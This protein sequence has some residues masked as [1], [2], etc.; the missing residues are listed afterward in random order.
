MWPST[1]AGGA[2]C[3]RGLVLERAH[4]FSPRVSEAVIHPR[5]R[6]V[7]RVVAMAGGKHKGRAHVLDVQWRAPVRQV[8]GSGPAEQGH[9]F[10][11]GEV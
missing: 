5:L 10:P 1:S 6:P 7:I 4:V 9:L 2:L 3:D 8:E 11:A